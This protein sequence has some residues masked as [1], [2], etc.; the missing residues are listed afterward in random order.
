MRMRTLRFG[1]LAWVAGV[2]LAA[3]A[4]F[5]NSAQASYY[6]NTLNTIAGSDG[7]S[8][9]SLNE[10]S[11]FALD[12]WASDPL[13]GEN[14]GT[15]S[16]TGVVRGV[17]GPSSADGF[18]GFGASNNAIEFT[19]V[20]DQLL[21]MEDAASFAGVQDLTMM[22]WFNIPTSIRTNSDLQRFFGGLYSDGSDGNT[23]GRYAFAVNSVVSDTSSSASRKG[24]LRAYTR[25]DDLDAAPPVELS[26]DSGNTAIVDPSDPTAYKNYRDGEWHFLV[27]TM[28]DAG[29]GL[30]KDYTVYV[31]GVEVYSN[32]LAGGAGHGLSARHTSG[33]AGMLAFGADPGASTEESRAFLGLMDEI[34]FI[35][36]ALTLGEIN[37]LY[38]AAQV[39]E[40]ST[41][42]LLGLAVT[43][44]VAR[45]RFAKK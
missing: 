18:S 45:R 32:I 11:G 29:N 3:S 12:S 33:P 1:R 9:W 6:I 26:S 41:V 22:L 36:R 15:F 44:L 4:M 19:G 27:M 43:G 30:D 7:I 14:N 21:Q 31:D 5:G 17:A 38:T 37:A 39:P 13:D 23:S 10:T 28:A 20:A 40:P 35:N 16:A 25:L 8:H 24:R 34:S 2:S 42:A